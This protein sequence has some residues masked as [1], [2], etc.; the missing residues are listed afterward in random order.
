MNEQSLESKITNHLIANYHHRG[1]DTFRF[2]DCAGGLLVTVGGKHPSRYFMRIY[3]DKIRQTRP[4]TAQE[5][6]R[7]V[8]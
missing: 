8:R 1:A 5:F 4:I 2:S 6:K 3:N 7:R